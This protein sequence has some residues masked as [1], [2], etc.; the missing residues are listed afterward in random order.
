LCFISRF[1]PNGHKRFF[2]I[3]ESFFSRIR[4]AMA[5]NVT[6]STTSGTGSAGHFVSS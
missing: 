4:V 3:H 5:G 2:A 1:A 6:T